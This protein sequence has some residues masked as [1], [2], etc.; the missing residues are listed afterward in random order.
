VIEYGEGVMGGGNEEGEDGWG[1]GEAT[2]LDV[3]HCRAL[4]QP[5]TRIH[6]QPKNEIRIDSHND[7][8]SGHYHT[9]YATTQ[10]GVRDDRERFVHDHV[11]QEESDE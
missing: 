11:C 7:Q 2:R 1:L 10:H 6:H 3:W 5:N 4:T 8:H 9:L